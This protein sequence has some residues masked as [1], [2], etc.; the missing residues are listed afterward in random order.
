[1]SKTNKTITKDEALNEAS[2]LLNDISDHKSW[3]KDNNKNWEDMQES[4][5]KIINYISN[6]KEK[7]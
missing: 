5:S 3:D 7:T 4:I 6:S 1:M 2:L